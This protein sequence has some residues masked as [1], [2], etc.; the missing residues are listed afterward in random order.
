MHGGQ[1]EGLE[2]PFEV[3]EHGTGLGCAGIVKV[4]TG[5]RTTEWVGL[6]QFLKVVA[7]QNGLSLGWKGPSRL[8]NL[9]IGWVQRVLQGCRALVRM[10]FGLERSFK[11]AEPQNTLGL[12]WK[13]P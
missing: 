12:G 6:E 1:Q 5:C 9:G 11:V 4:L 2:G 13:G 10:G 3:R 7:P 8:Q